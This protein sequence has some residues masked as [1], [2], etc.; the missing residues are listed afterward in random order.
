MDNSILCGT[1]AST[2]KKIQEVI[3]MYFT[4]KRYINNMRRALTLK[5][6]VSLLR[7]DPNKD[8]DKIE[9]ILE[10]LEVAQKVLDDAEKGKYTVPQISILQDLSLSDIRKDELLLAI[11]TREEYNVFLSFNKDNTRKL[12]PFVLG[13]PEI[14]QYLSLSDYGMRMN[15]NSKEEISKDVRLMPLSLF[16]KYGNVVN[17]TSRRKNSYETILC[18]YNGYELV[19]VH[20]YKTNYSYYYLREA[21]VNYCNSGNREELLRTLEEEA[22]SMFAEHI[23]RISKSDKLA[24]TLQ[25]KSR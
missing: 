11:F 3:D 9:Y 14:D 8:K 2:S 4:K 20:E 7:L 21:T 22:S 25:V 13:N 6:K 24:R 5:S 12:D 19:Y 16:V 17:A 1:F 15:I 23:D 10:I 18:Q